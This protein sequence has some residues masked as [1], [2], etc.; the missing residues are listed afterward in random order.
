MTRTLELLFFATA[1]EAVGRPRVE[2]AIG[3]DGEE[4][5]SVLDRLRSEYPRLR[6]ILATSRF[7]LNGRYLRGRTARVRPGDELA[8]HP[9]YS[10]G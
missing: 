3:E 5:G 9:P 4:L 2:W 8:V 1:R 7:V 6:P 10:G